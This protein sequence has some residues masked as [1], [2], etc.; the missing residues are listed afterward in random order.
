MTSPL[1]RLNPPSLPMAFPNQQILRPLHPWKMKCGK[2]GQHQPQFVCSVEKFTL[3]SMNHNCAHWQIQKTAL[4]VSRKD[5]AF[6]S[7]RGLDGGTTVSGT[8]ITAHAAGIEVFATGGIGGVHRGNPQDVSA[9]LPTLAQVPMVIVCAG[10]KSILDIPATKE[11][12]ETFGVPVLG[13]QTDELPAFFS[14]HSGVKA[15]HRVNSPEE[16]AATAIAQWEL[17]LQTAIMVAVPLPK[18]MEIP[19]EKVNLAIDQALKDAETSGITGPK[20]TPFLLQRVKEITKGESMDANIELLK[21][22]ARIASEIAVAL[23][24][25][26]GNS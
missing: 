7:A 26:S 8:M 3:A 11:T 6:A 16:V 18:E 14:V 19:A 21:N 15:D 4:K 1:S 13:Y 12:L 2:P 17:G 24:T 23:K 10:A 25:L 22:N 20:I 5:L 9:D